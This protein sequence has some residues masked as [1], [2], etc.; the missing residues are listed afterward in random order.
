[1]EISIDK[2]QIGVGVLLSLVAA[3][4]SY[5][6]NV[7]E[8]SLKQAEFKLKASEENRDNRES[9]EKKQLMVYEAVVKSLES[10]DSKRQRVSKALVTSMLEDPLRTELLTVLAESTSPEIKKEAQSTLALESAFKVE[11]A[12]VQA[13]QPQIP[14]KWEDWDFDI[15]WCER[16]G[17]NA[18]VQAEKI[19]KQL[20]GE[21]AKG[22]LR[23]RLLPDSLNARP[24]YQHN[25]YVIRYNLGE[26]EQSNRFKML[27]DKVIGSSAAFIPSL[28]HQST[29][30]YLSAFVCPTNL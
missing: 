16:S 10:G 8:R 7:T 27:A 9:V 19:K 17:E 24:G 14:S 18:R 28:S 20:E 25:G 29:K 6:L 1:M 26:E 15:F 2:L 30:W 5:Q 4:S 23:V 22:R 3:Y 12:T 21:G 13:P 11:E